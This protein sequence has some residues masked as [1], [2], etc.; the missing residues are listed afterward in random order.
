M[1]KYT[2]RNQNIKQNTKQTPVPGKS[3]SDVKSK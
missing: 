3:G 1:K 2:R